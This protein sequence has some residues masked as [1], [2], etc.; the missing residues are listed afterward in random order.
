MLNHARIPL[1]KDFCHWET[2]EHPERIIR[3]YC[4][5]NLTAYVHILSLC[6]NTLLETRGTVGLAGSLMGKF[7]QPGWVMEL[8][9]QPQQFYT[10]HSWLNVLCWTNHLCYPLLERYR[11]A[12]HWLGELQWFWLLFSIY[13]FQ[14]MNNAVCFNFH[15]SRFSFSIF[16]LCL[17]ATTLT[18]V[19]GLHRL[20]GRAG[21]LFHCSEKPV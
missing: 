2:R 17:R 12:E 3:N 16:V 1:I 20:Q 18:T 15:I 9:S 14:V 21:W 13:P 7:P 8:I 6:F 4:E 11:L 19:W 10:T 5:V